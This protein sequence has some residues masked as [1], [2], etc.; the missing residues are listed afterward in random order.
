MHFEQELVENQRIC[1][2]QKRINKVLNKDTNTSFTFKTAT[3]LSVMD[4]TISS[5]A[6]SLYLS[7]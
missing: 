4:L 7:Y 1:E 6:V 2:L 3:A 5:G